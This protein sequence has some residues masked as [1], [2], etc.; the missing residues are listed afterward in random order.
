MT[1]AYT[2]AELHCGLTGLHNVEKYSMLELVQSFFLCFF[3]QFS[4]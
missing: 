1:A 2:A 3:V 4:L